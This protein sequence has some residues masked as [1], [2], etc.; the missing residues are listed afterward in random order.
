[1]RSIP[2][3]AGITSEAVSVF[4]P[5]DRRHASQKAHRQN[6]RNH[7]TCLDKMVPYRVKEVLISVVGLF[8]EVMRSLFL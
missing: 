8:G 1:M 3:F 2:R 4:G 5:S 7:M 6:C